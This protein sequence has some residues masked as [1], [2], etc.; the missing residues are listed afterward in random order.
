MQYNTAFFTTI[1][2]T[3][4]TFST[5]ILSLLPIGQLSVTD[6]RMRTEYWLIA[7]VKPV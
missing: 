2:S 3:V 5:A 7:L 6:E 4:G 1:V